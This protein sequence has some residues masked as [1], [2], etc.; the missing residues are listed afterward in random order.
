MAKLQ[1]IGDFEDELVDAYGEDIY[2]ELVS[3]ENDSDSV[4]I[5]GMATDGFYDI[6]LPSGTTVFGFSAG[7]LD[8]S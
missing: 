8:F 1:F 6:V 5:L 4:D 3:I 7:L 2:H